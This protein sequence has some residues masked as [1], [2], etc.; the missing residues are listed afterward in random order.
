MV[1]HAAAIEWVWVAIAAVGVVL[2]TLLFRTTLQVQ[3]RLT[4]D[5]YATMPEK[6]LAAAA[7]RQEALRLGKQMLMLVG[8]AI[9]L[10]LAPPPPDLWSV[11]QVVVSITTLVGVSTLMSITSFFER[12]AQRD[13]AQS[14]YQLHKRSTGEVTPGTRREDQL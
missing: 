7:C 5:P 1:I 13:V 6:I 10:F 3:M 14:A 8:G 12:Q 2:G 11:P 4:K 9:S